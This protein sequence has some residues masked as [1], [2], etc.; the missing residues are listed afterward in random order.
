M[1]TITSTLIIV[2]ILFCSSV[3]AQD[4]EL[5]YTDRQ[6]QAATEKNPKDRLAKLELLIAEANDYERFVTLGYAA[7]AALLAGNNE[8]ADLYSN[9]LL[10][11]APQ[12]QDDWNY[13]NAIH[14]GHLVLGRIAVKNG[15]I[16][17]AKNH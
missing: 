17:E 9:E 4:N 13:G 5:P 15:N 11:I 14:D 3:Y 6:I 7:K 8:K 16:D 2:L 1:K 10:E 12:Y